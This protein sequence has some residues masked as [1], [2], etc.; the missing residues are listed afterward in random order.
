MESA[1]HPLHSPQFS[2]K[3]TYTIIVEDLHRGP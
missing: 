1:I 3:Y 2:L